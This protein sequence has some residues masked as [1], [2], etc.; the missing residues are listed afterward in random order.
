MLLDWFS[1]SIPF[2][3]KTRVRLVKFSAVQLC[4]IKITKRENEP[5]SSDKNGDS[6]WVNG[7]RE[8][9]YLIYFG[10]TLYIIERYFSPYNLM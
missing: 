10:H 6:L 3:H 4:P 2:F 7:Y 5:K 9:V 8:N 1:L